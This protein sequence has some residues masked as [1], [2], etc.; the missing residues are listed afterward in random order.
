MTGRAP[1]IVAA[2][3]AATLGLG[4]AVLAQDE[5]NSY[6]G[7]LDTEGNLSKV[8]LGE[9]RLGC[10]DKRQVLA[11]WSLE[12]PKGEPGAAGDAGAPGEA[13]AQGDQGEQGE[14]GKKG[15]PGTSATYF[16]TKS[17][18]EAVVVAGSAKCDDGDLVTGGGYR[19]LSGPPAAVADDYPSGK[20]EWTISL[21]VT[22]GSMVPMDVDVYAVCSDLEPLR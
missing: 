22:D 4:G 13:G 16:V 14:R 15:N 20:R 10:C 1:V 11:Q 8:A 21:L 12:G 9:E 6:T 7:C 2:A 5:A 17:F 3:L 19:K 18:S